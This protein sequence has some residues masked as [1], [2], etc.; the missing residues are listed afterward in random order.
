[1]IGLVYWISLERLGR[2]DVPWGRWWMT[3]RWVQGIEPS[4]RLKAP[5]CVASVL[6]GK[7]RRR[8]LMGGAGRS[9]VEGTLMLKVT[10]CSRW[11]V[12]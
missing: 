8:R 5:W 4:L 2:W 9:Q 10:D 1:M 3:R 11:L 6:E 7:G 12:P